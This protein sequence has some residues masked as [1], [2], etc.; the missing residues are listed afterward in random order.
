MARGGRVRQIRLSKIAFPVTALGPGHRI[1]LWVAGC[2]IGC[3]GCMTPELWSANSGTLVDHDDVLERLSNISMEIDG[4][5]ITGGEPFEQAEEVAALLMLIKERYPTWTVI[6]FTGYHFEELTQRFKS[7]DILIGLV[8]VMV[9]G[10]F[11][12]GLSSKKP[13]IASSNQSLI[14]CSQLGQIMIEEIKRQRKPIANLGIGQEGE[15]WL[16]GIVHA[17]QR[18]NLQASLRNLER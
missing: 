6:L 2:S 9:A 1:A 18:R 3:K 17:D 8:D 4:L 10:P 15:D 11:Q 16:I 5:S 13:L 14:A 12:I 7:A